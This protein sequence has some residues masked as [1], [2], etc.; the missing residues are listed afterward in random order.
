MLNAQ[1]WGRKGRQYESKSQSL[2]TLLAIRDK[3]C[4]MC[5]LLLLIGHPAALMTDVTRC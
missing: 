3:S 2:V 1:G 5:Q 4:K